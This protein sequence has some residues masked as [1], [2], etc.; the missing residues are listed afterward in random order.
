MRPQ[1]VALFAAVLALLAPA[2]RLAAVQ[3]LE[4]PSGFPLSFS[5]AES[6]ASDQFGALYVGKGSTLIVFDQGGG[7]P[8]QYAT[9]AAELSVLSPSR[10][11]PNVVWALDAPGNKIWYI[12]RG[13]SA[14]TTLSWT[15]PTAASVPKGLVQGTTGAIWFTEYGASKIGRL[16]LDG[17]FDEFPLAPLS[18][19]WGITVADNGSVWFVEYNANKVGHVTPNG[20]ISDYPIPTAGAFPTGIAGGVGVV[21]FTET[22][23]SQVGIFSTT[24]LAFSREILTTAAD[25][26]PGGIVLGAD[27]TFWFTEYLGHNIGR[28]H[29]QII[30]EYPLPTATANPSAI[31]RGVDGSLWFI[32]ASPSQLGRVEMVTRGDANNDGIVDLSDVFYLIDYLF[33]GGPPPVP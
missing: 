20:F 23:Q 30:D 6:V 33:A 29:G 19:P 32:E 9:P 27:G 25:S 5:G 17:S 4:Y 13:T 14:L 18:Q 22:G 8:A 28:V 7:L 12:E 2:P 31:A 1:P 10:T 26:A 24:N 3:V 15:I 16:N 21:A 11:Q